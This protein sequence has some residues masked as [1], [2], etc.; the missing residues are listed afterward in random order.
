MKLKIE[1]GINLLVLGR[2]QQEIGVFGELKESLKI[3]ANSLEV[4]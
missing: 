3:R 1:A 4:I 2:N